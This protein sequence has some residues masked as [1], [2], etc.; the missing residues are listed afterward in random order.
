MRGGRSLLAALESYLQCSRQVSRKDLPS[1]R[2]PTDEQVEKVLLAVAEREG[3]EVAELSA[4]APLEEEDLKD[5]VA[6]ARLEGL[7][8][9]REIPRGWLACL[10]FGRRRA[11]I[12]LTSKGEAYLLTK[13]GRNCN[14]TGRGAAHHVNA[15]TATEQRKEN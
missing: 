4:L 14:R 8:E 9:I 3:C 5:A 15:T 2:Y 12:H 13:G 7:V 6:A 1:Q 10:P 11:R